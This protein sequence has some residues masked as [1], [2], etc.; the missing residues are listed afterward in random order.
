MSAKTRIKRPTYATPRKSPA[1]RMLHISTNYGW[2]Q[3][4]P[5]MPAQ[6]VKLGPGTTYRRQA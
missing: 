2:L 6:F 5:G 4:H 1:G 3:F